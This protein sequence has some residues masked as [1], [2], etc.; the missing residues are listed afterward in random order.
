VLLAS[1]LALLVLIGGVGRANVLRWLADKYCLW[2]WPLVGLAGYIITWVEGRY[3]GPLL[4]V[5]FLAIFSAI[6]SV[7]S[8]TFMPTV[9]VILG[10]AG[11]T[12]VVPRLFDVPGQAATAIQQ[13]RRSDWHA[14]HT[15][16]A[17]SRMIAQAIPLPNGA[18]VGVLGS[19]FTAFFLSPGGLRVRLELPRR[20]VEEYCALDPAGRRAI[21]DLMR[22]HGAPVI[23]AE[24]WIPCLAEGGWRE[25][26]GT[27]FRLLVQEP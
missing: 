17:A 26:P 24:R 8:A 4:V 2:G 6:V 13:L 11:L 10:V 21:R 14:D 3:V 19:P 25:I 5:G 27:D 9:R 23:I 12:L 18:G 16:L 20:S 7:A 1:V 22:S 15:H